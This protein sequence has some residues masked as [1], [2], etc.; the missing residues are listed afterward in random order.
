MFNVNAD[1]EI[2]DKELKQTDEIFLMLARHCNPY[3]SEK[4]DQ[5]FS[6][7]KMTFEYLVDFAK[8][9]EK[10]KQKITLVITPRCEEYIKYGD[11]KGDVDQGFAAQNKSRDDLVPYIEYSFPE[12]YEN[13]H[14]SHYNHCFFLFFTTHSSFEES[15]EYCR[16]WLKKITTLKAF[17]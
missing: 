10:H 7:S 11:P 4:I 12:G 5:V 8:V 6:S 15:E 16:Y 14:G 3:Y 17:L 13:P 1:E 2:A 9:L